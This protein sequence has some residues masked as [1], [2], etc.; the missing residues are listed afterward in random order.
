M[1]KRYLFAVVWVLG[2]V[3]AIGYS[4]AQTPQGP[5]VCSADNNGTLRFGPYS[6]KTNQAGQAQMTATVSVDI[7][8][9]A[10]NP[11]TYR[12]VQNLTATSQGKLA[13]IV[14]GEIPP[15]TSCDIAQKI[16]LGGTEYYRVDRTTPGLTWISNNQPPTVWAQCQ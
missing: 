13:M 7:K 8:V 15:G 12:L 5:Y 10:A 11:N 4:L 3:V 16:A 6:C 14:A 1:K 2:W 9:N